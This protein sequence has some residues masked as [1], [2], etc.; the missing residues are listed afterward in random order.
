M[1]SQ[2]GKTNMKKNE[3]YVDYKCCKKYELFVN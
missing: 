1:F 2:I 3:I